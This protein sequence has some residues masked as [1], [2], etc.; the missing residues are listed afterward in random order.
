MKTVIKPTLVDR[1][2]AETDFEK[3]A[4]KYFGTIPYLV[5]P[6]RYIK[7]RNISKQDIF[8]TG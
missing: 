7:K 8:Q 2:Q 4:K 1:K 5:V 6:K 3:I